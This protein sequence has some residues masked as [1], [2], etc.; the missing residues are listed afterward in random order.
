M[1]RADLRAEVVCRTRARVRLVPR[2]RHREAVAGVVGRSR[3]SRWIRRRPRRRHRG[4]S[5]GA[6]AADLSQAVSF[7]V[8]K[9]GGL[10]IPNESRRPDMTRYRSAWLVGL[11]ATLSLAAHANA[12]VEA[13]GLFKDRAMIRVLGS[14]HYL[15]VGQTSPE[16]ATLV[17]SDA[18]HAV[19]RY[20]DETYRLTL[21]DRVGGTFQPATQTSISIS[22]DSIGQYRIQ[23]TINGYST[24]FL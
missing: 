24:D 3:G 7:T 10:M 12:P 11:V 5:R 20:K 13:V 2:I 8:L 1:G 16:G 23:G 18:Q 21:T 15:L 4:S 22:P 14:E 17:E 6:C 19:V 9:R